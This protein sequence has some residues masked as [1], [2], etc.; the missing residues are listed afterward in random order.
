MGKFVIR[1]T[2]T[3]YKFDL[4]ASNA[5]VIATSEVYASSA[6]CR[7]G[8]QGIVRC[9]DSAPVADLTC[10]EGPV[11][12]PRF[13]LFADKSGGYRFRLKARNGKVIAVSQSYS[14]RTACEN[15]IDSVR[16]NARNAGI[17]EV[18]P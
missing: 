10:A 9:V 17:E 5:E 4:R 16:K 14:S 6:A 11:P 7:K 15:G 13:E 12:T 8:I 3:G 2:A 18:F 1:K